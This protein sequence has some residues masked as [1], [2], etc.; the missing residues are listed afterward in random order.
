MNPAAL[1]LGQYVP[2]ES[3]VHRLDPRA[4]F[5]CLLPLVLGAFA[6]GTGPRLAWWALVLSGIAALARL[7]WRALLRSARPLFLLTGLAFVFN[8]AALL[9]EAPLLRA[10]TQ[11]GAAALRLL[12]AM[13]LAM[14]LPLTTAPLDLAD[15]LEAMLRPLSRLGLPGQ[16]CA[17]MAGMTLRF[18]PLLMEETNRIAKAQLSRGA[19]LDQ[20]GPLRRM[21]AFIPVIVPLFVILF[22][23]ADETALAMEARGYA[24]GVGRTRRRPLRWKK[25][26]TTAAILCASCACLAALL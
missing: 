12:L 20:G 17:M 8:A 25:S 4:K 23:R 24:G 19:R 26:D 11:G 21:M 16:E 22:R 15:G 2:A 7:P 13:S 3:P 5:L 1:S 10:L 14:L 6:A 18:I 9:G